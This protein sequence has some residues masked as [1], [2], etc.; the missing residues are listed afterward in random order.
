MALSASRLATALAVS[1][2]LV[3][4]LAAQEGVSPS[5]LAR[6]FNDALV[7]GDYPTAI[8]A[9][10]RLAEV[11]SGNAILRYNLACAYALG[12]RPEEALES[13]RRSA[14]LGFDHLSTFEADGDLESL[15]E[16]PG[17]PAVAEAIRHN[18]YLA[19]REFERLAESAQVRTF[20]PGGKVPDAPAPLIVALHGL[21]GNADDF[22][23]VYREAADDRDAIL[24]VPEAVRPYPP[25]YTWGDQE[26]AESLVL[27]A[28]EQARADYPIDPDR[29]VLTGFS[30]GGY[31]TYSLALRHPELF[32]GAIPVGG[33]YHFPPAALPDG[34]NER[35]RFYIMYGGRDAALA[36]NRRAA[37]ILREAGFAVKLRIYPE[38]GHSY[39]S[40]HDRELRRALG[41]VLR[42]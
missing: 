1:L 2:L 23:V 19:R 10:E 29:I 30:Q 33:S 5:E 11:E 3:G 35:P 20:L 28:I 24:I 42:R 17:F 27:R 34:R 12:G 26:E 15:R 9:G 41:F 7:G 4:A 18:A 6:R 22:A 32:A 40:G 25:G 36:N 38:V 14:D 8:E 39:P 31:L 21:G 16:L 37:R 13:L